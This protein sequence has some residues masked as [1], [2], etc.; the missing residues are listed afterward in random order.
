MSIIELEMRKLQALGFKAKISSE[1][2]D[3]RMS[4]YHIGRILKGGN[5]IR[6]H[7]DSGQNLSTQEMGQLFAQ[8]FE[9]RYLLDDTLEI[10][11]QVEVYATLDSSEANSLMTEITEKEL[12]SA[13]MLCKKKKSPGPDGISY[14]FYIK[15]FEVIKFE[16][17]ALFNGLLKGTLTPPK[18]WS[19]GV[20]TLIKKEKLPKKPADFRPITL[21]NTDYKLFTKVLALRLKKF[22]SK[23][24]GPTQS[25]CREDQNV[26]ESLRSVRWLLASA[27]ID[28]N[29]KFAIMTMDLQ[30]AFD[31]VSHQYL[32]RVMESMKFP[33][34][35]VQCLQKIYSVSSSR[36]RI[37]DHITGCIEIK[38]SVR[39]GCPISMQ[40]FALYLTPLLFKLEQKIVGV[41]TPTG[42][43][44]MKVYAD[45]ID[46]FLREVDNIDLIMATVHNYGRQSGAQINI[47]KS[48][49][50]LVNAPNILGPVMVRTVDEL[51]ILG[52]KTVAKWSGMAAANFGKV[53]AGL[54]AT[55]KA[56]Q[57]RRLNLAQR[58]WIANTFMLSK[59]WYLSQ[60]IIWKNAHLAKFI[61]VVGQFIWRG[62]IYRVERSQLC[63]EKTKGGLGLQS[64]P[65]KSLALF[66]RTAMF[67]PKALG[68]HK[69]LDPFVTLQ[70]KA[71]EYRAMKERL[72]RFD[73]I[74]SATSA[75]ILYKDLL[76]AQGGGG[77]LDVELKFPEM[78]WTNV[79]KLFGT[80][81]IPTDWLST[82]YMLVNDKLSY[83]VK[84]L[85]HKI[86]RSDRC[87]NCGGQDSRLHRISACTGEDAY[88]W[89]VEEMRRLTGLRHDSVFSVLNLP[90][91]T[92]QGLAL[93][94]VV[95]GLIHFNWVRRGEGGAKGLRRYLGEHRF[96]MGGLLGRCG[97]WLKRFKF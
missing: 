59:L 89:V 32:W 50:M 71:R 31:R 15:A 46:L 80:R 11:D 63:R 44:K 72:P 20:I 47:E 40:L 18:G 12:Y 8:H 93:K 97:I 45:D 66:L 9:E 79:W 14:E 27:E 5:H 34:G 77:P 3:E 85:A 2:E 82:V 13:L 21:L 58:V 4:V 56:W 38:R 24:L 28:P 95:A 86:T 35:F 67:G 70:F 64:V 94:W 57:A 25:A 78:R 75:I 69:D 81:A 26:I 51:N 10:P 74:Q 55:C 39:Q 84:T 73:P 62:S 91:V 17:L 48:G 7:N 53:L 88:L 37:N 60:V 61:S 16:L 22:M 36:I 90:G 33:L 76:Q 54:V 29:M 92:G 30:Q 49:M 43:K 23:L 19:D 65:E 68:S 83:G 52:M 87:A 1:V 42:T 96:L 6:L 41:Q